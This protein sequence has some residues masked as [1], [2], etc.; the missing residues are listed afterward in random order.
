MATSRSHSKLLCVIVRVAR[1]EACSSSLSLVWSFLNTS[2]EDNVFP[3]KSTNT[4]YPQAL[5]PTRTSLLLVHPYCWYI[6]AI[7]MSPGVLLGPDALGFS[8]RILLGSLFVGASQL[9]PPLSTLQHHAKLQDEPAWLWAAPWQ[10]TEQ[11]SQRD[12]K[13][14]HRHSQFLHVFPLL[15][16]CSLPEE[17]CTCPADGTPPW[18]YSKKPL[19]DLANLWGSWAIGKG[20]PA[21]PVMLSHLGNAILCP[22]VPFEVIW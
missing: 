11:G 17:P 21:H 3:N 1:Y 6:H 5:V 8:S 10:F 2:R 12:V 7:R 15:Y 22:A 18:F 4:S 9:P 16:S 20:C 19:N 14:Q 13:S